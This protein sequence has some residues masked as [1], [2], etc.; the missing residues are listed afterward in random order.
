MKCQKIKIIRTFMELF[1]FTILDMTHMRIS[2]F[3]LSRLKQE[4][5]RR[6]FEFGFFP[7]FKVGGVERIIV[8]IYSSNSFE[9]GRVVGLES[10]SLL[11][12]RSQVRFPLVSILVGKSI[13]SLL[14]LRTGPLQ[15]G[16]GI[17][18]LG[19]VGPWIEYRVLKKKKT[20]LNC[21]TD[22]F[23]NTFKG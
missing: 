20:F 23:F 7:K 1:Y 12:S 4:S 8:S 17:G 21:Y 9:F 19:L 3:V 14:W 10:W 15:V 22:S 16:G 18:P 11:L 5:S 2:V 6:L 13:Q